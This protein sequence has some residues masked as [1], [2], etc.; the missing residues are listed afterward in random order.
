MYPENTLG[1]TSG[2][3]QDTEVCV[4][5]PSNARIHD[6]L[7]DTCRIQ[8]EY[9][10]P[11]RRLAWGWELERAGCLRGWGFTVR[12]GSVGGLDCVSCVSDAVRCV[13]A[14]WSPLLYCVC[15]PPS[16]ICV[17]PREAPGRIHNT[18]TS[19]DGRA[20]RPTITGDFRFSPPAAGWPG[21][22]AKR[23]RLLAVSA[24]AYYM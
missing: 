19:E 12:T 10:R 15:V 2:Y 11:I 7:Q 24:L 1:Y 5:P 13:S 22:A 16:K 14:R 20:T 3:M 9:M 18:H 6:R 23:K 21:R 4:Y 17:L 8:A